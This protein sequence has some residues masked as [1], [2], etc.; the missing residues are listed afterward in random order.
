M[1]QYE[2]TFIIDP[3]LSSDELKAVAQIYIDFITKAGGEIV[4]VDEPG[5]RAL[6]YAINKRSSGVFCTIEYKIEDSK[7]NPK[8]ELQLRRDERI[9]RFLT[10]ALD[11]YG[12]KF[13][14]DKRAGKIGTVKKKA[15]KNKKKTTAEEVV[16]VTEATLE[17]AT[18]QNVVDDVIVPAAE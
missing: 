16:P 5:L 14:E 12:V 7:F 9:M 18:S 10:I 13:N 2:L 6:A 1:K 11:K 4:H 3:V 8:I 17:V 15:D